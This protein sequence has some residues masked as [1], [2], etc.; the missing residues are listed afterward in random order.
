MAM[1]LHGVKGDFGW[2]AFSWIK[3]LRLAQNYGWQPAGTTI[4]AAELKSMPNGKWDGNYTTNDRQIV[5][6]ADAKALA[7]ALDRAIKDIPSDDVIA[8][9]RA[10]SGGIQILPNPPEISD[11]DWFCGA[12]SKAEIREFISFCNRGEFQIG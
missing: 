11:L 5:S 2:N 1:H 10:P 7:S 9:Y 3:L 6:A 8:Q 12:E 4:S